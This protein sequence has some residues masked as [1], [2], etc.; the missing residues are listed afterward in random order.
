MIEINNLWKIY[1]KRTLERTNALSSV[2]FKIKKEEIISI[3]GKTG[4]GKTTL[5]NILLGITK[6]TDGKVILNNEIII[7]K[8]SKKRNLRKITNFSISWTSII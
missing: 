3:V 4:S 6:P 5:A 2:S 7:N 1:N 8:K